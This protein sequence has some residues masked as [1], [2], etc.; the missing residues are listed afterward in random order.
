MERGHSYASSI[1]HYLYWQI[2]GPDATRA[3]R[4]GNS[5]TSNIKSVLHS[6]PVP[7]SW[8]RL[9]PVAVPGGRR[10]MHWRLAT[11]SD[12]G[13]LARRHRGLAGRGVHC[14]GRDPARSPGQ[15]G[16]FRGEG[17]QFR[18]EGGQF[19]GV[20]SERAVG[21]CQFGAFSSM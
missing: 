21:Y 14:T 18:G 6:G 1:Y 15:S 11:N 9:T 17:G 2:A 5:R 16:Q 20:S 7:G 3:I 19:G 4:R 12:G 8:L 13:A 10:A